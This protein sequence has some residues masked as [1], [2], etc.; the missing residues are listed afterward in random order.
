MKNFICYNKLKL[1]EQS[2]LKKATI[3]EKNVYTIL[4]PKSV[5]MF[6]TCICFIN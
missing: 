6:V 5:D 3:R 2:I 4:A 1:V